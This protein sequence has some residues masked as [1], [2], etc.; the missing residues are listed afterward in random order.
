M[1]PQDKPGTGTHAQGSE[2]AVDESMRASDP[3]AK[4]TGPPDVATE[5]NASEMERLRR[6]AAESY[7]RFLRERAEVE[8][9]KKRMQR[10]KAE[11]IRF[12][13]EPLVRDLL[14][15]VDN[16]ERALEH[17]PEA[18][19][20]VRQGL[21]MVLKSLLDVLERHDVKR[22]QSRGQG[23]DPAVHEAIAQI[24]SH[25]HEPNSVVEEHQ[26]GYLLNDRLLR[27]ALVTVNARKPTTDA[28]ERGRNSD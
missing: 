22:V 10:E 20:S 6:E 21:E 26:V 19:T 14:P 13:A 15:V 25:E 24:E 7:D 11:A 1:G 27:P 5:G 18:E 2:I 9:F 23:F 28:V 17:C 12:A 16:L 3:E 8:N 4:R